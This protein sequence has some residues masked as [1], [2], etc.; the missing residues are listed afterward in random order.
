M[1]KKMD[2]DVE[3]VFFSGGF[4][5]TNLSVLVQDSLYNCCIGCLQFSSK[6]I[7]RF[8]WV[9]IRWELGVAEA[10]LGSA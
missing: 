7:M 2:N 6:V 8:I 4:T 9:C 1:E 10:L 5:K 3:A